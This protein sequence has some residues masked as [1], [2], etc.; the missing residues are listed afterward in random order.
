MTLFLLFVLGGDSQNFLS[1]FVSFIA[2]LG[3]KILILF[4]FKVLFEADIN[5][6]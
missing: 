5:K 4:R 2:T 3:C 1:K 6:G